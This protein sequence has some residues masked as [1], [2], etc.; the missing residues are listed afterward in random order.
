MKQNSQ[1]AFT[2]MELLIVVLILG[3]V[4]ALVI[5]FI[6]PEKKI[7]TAKDSIVKSDLSQIVNALRAY[8]ANPDNNNEYPSAYD[9]L[10]ALIQD[11]ELISL[12]SQQEGAV[13]CPNEAIT[14]GTT[15]CYVVSEESE[16]KLIAVWGSLFSKDLQAWCWDSVN[17]AYTEKKTGEALPT[18]FDPTCRR[19]V[20]TSTPSLTP[21]PTTTPIP[22][23]TTGSPSTSC[24][25]TSGTCGPG[26]RTMLLNAPQPCKVWST[27]ERCT[28]HCTAGFDCV[29]GSCKPLCSPG[30]YC[31]SK[32]CYTDA[33]KDGYA[34]SSGT[35]TC[36]TNESKGL[37]CYDDDKNSNPGQEKYFFTRNRHGNF[38]YNCSGAEER[39]S[40]CTNT[41]KAIS[42]YT[43]GTC[44]SEYGGAST[45]NWSGCNAYICGE[46]YNTCN[47]TYYSRSGIPSFFSGVIPQTSNCAP[48]EYYCDITSN[49]IA[50]G[51]E[52]VSFDSNQT[53]KGCKC[54]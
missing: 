13:S 51:I 7:N 54:H 29:S 19:P 48:I 2:L 50:K 34:G 12:P 20:P 45:L 26:T 8:N 49:G 42:C 10:S 39:D 14:T 21:A 23:C 52:S 35:K 41:G 17:N 40:E 37:D 32:F 1:R 36:Q 15:Y 3:M 30:N 28:V 25:P 47:V 5:A 53:S 9:G 46:Y 6:N 16:G 31:D 33:D 24:T 11:G 43:S 38:D 22:K 18:E 27:P 4:A 44:Q